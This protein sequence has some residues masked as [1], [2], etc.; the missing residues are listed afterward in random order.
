MD[1]EE[2]AARR[3]PLGSAGESGW[4]PV[5]EPARL[6]S[7]EPLPGQVTAPIDV[8]GD[9]GGLLDYLASREHYREA[10]AG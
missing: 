4:R 9:V 2:D 7:F 1:D 8:V 10:R 5:R 6:V 3:G